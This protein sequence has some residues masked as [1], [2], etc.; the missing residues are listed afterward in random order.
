MLMAP[1]A[2]CDHT[3]CFVNLVIMA[4]LGFLE[5]LFN[6]IILVNL[7]ILLNL[8]KSYDDT[9]KLPR[10]CPLRKYMVCVV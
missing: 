10:S 3:N 4:N 8:V 9:D 1:H 7:V 5:N 6:L 2:L